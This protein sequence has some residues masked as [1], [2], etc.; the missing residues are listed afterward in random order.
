MTFG[1]PDQ[2]AEAGGSAL[3]V[4]PTVAKG[5]FLYTAAKKG[6]VTVTSSRPACPTAK[7]GT[8]TC[9]AI[10]AFRISVTVA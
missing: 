5:S 7:P 6:T 9:H 4:D 3:K 8:M 2:L 10:E 1:R